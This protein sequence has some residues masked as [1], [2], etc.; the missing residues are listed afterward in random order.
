MFLQSIQR[1]LTEAKGV[2]SILCKAHPREL[3]TAF[4]VLALR[5]VHHT[6]ADTATKY[7]QAGLL[8]GASCDE[9][10]TVLVRRQRDIE[11]AFVSHPLNRLA[12]SVKLACGSC[13]A[14]NQ[15]ADGGLPSHSEP[16]TKDLTT[17][18]PASPL[19]G[20]ILDI[21]ASINKQSNG[22]AFDN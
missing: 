7:R 6:L 4:T 5:H 21:R 20:S 11:E 17:P 14:T 22:P 15:A 13:L 12:L 9:I 10:T 18:I 19:N 3:I 2:L 1:V 16:S 8:S